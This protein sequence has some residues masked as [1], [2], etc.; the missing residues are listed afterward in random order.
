MLY[1]VFIETMLIIMLLVL[2][3]YQR[4][5]FVKKLSHNPTVKMKE[6]IIEDNKTPNFLGPNLRETFRVAL[7]EKDCLVQFLEFENKQLQK[8]KGKQFNGYLENISVGGLKLICSY[9]LPAKQS[10]ILE[11]RFSLK[12]EDFCL[13]GEIMRKEEHN[14]K[15]M[16]A[17]GIHFIDIS[18]EEQGLLNQAL[19]QVIYERRKKIS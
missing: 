3:V 4:N 16:F 1:I 2:F 15:N 9:N 5:S 18:N 13:K 7:N 12:G 10:I 6:N 11:I 19:N 8:L 14:H 17:Y